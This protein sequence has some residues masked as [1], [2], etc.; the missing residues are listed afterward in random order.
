MRCSDVEAFW[1]EMREGGEP[2]SEHVLAHLRRC[3]T[4]QE[5]F[6]QCEGVAYCL[7]CLPVVEPPKSLVPRILEHIA[8][9][10]TRTRGPAGTDDVARINSPLGD[11]I[12]A[13]RPSGITF[14]GLVRG[15]DADAA[16]ERVER[17]LRRPLRDAA[18]PQWVV[19]AVD[20]FFKTWQVD[21]ARVDI[22]GLSDFEQAALRKA[23]QI[24][25]GEVR[26]YGW[27]AREIGHPLAARAVGQAMA[28]NPVA[29]L[30]PCHRVVDASGAL[31]NYGYGIEVKARLLRMEGYLKSGG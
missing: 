24:P 17:R 30:F 7:N 1:D 13:W 31:H 26:S 22:S 9:M 27:I 20:R 2:R 25:P 8:S 19:D 23:A 21:M 6:E 29:L 14:V 10:R 18:P 16:R 28:R 12:V 5:A 3:R 4:C 15:G 11:L